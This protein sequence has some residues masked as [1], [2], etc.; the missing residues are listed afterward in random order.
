MSRVAEQVAEALSAAIAGTVSTGAPLAPGTS[1]RLGGEAAVL[2][3][4]ATEGDLVTT[5]RA[6]AA[7]GLEVLALGRGSNVLISD[8]GFPGVVV[9]LGKG[10][11]WIRPYPPPGPGAEAGGATPLPR[12]ANWA[13]RR[14]L[15]GLEFAVAIPASLGGAVRMNAGAHDSSFSAVLDAVR[16][17]HLGAPAAEELPAGALAMGYRTTGLGAADIV[18][19]A[20]LRLTPADPG[21]V[22]ERMQHY[23]EHRAAT[24]PPEPRNAGSM[25]RN[26]PA[27]AP[28]AGRLIESAGLKGFRIGGAEVSTRHANFFVA[29]PGSTAGDVYR[30][31]AE[32]Q[33]RV[34]AESGVRLVPEVRL[35]GEFDGPDLAPAR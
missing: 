3:E 18:C 28:P 8:R 26:P 35:I 24:Q 23:R 14:G 29:R 7:A 32:V 4:A 31:L 15:S 16:I 33:A 25:F 13:A 21:E 11:E 34:Q 1:F 12:L 9:R 5:G 10:F 19:S 6:A 20:R 17:Y 30:L 22:T 27:P 2:V